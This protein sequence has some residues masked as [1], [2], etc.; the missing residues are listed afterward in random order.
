MFCQHVCVWATAHVCISENNLQEMGLSF[1]QID[2]VNWAQDC[3]GAP[4][5]TDLS[6]PLTQKSVF[7]ILPVW[8]MIHACNPSTWEDGVVEASLGSAAR[9][10]L[11]KR[12]Y[13]HQ[14]EYTTPQC[15]SH[16]TISQVGPHHFHPLGK[17]SLIEAKLLS[18]PP[19]ISF[20]FLWRK[21]CRTLDIRN[22]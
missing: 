7:Y 17:L 18:P 15:L 14:R 12:T 2:P 3:Q 8:G 19:T 11:R 10:C 4:L 1:H 16:W 9:P 20:P 21:C 13:L 5:S 22:T 6:H